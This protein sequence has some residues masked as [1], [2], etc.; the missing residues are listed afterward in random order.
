LPSLPLCTNCSLRS[1]VSPNIE[2]H[3]FCNF[4]LR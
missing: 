4:Q 1:T 3:L 2:R